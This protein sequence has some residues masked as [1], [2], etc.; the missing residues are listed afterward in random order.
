MFCRFQWS[1]VLA[2]F[3]V[4]RQHTSQNFISV[5]WDTATHGEEPPGAGE[6][7]AC[8]SLTDLFYAVQVPVHS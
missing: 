4:L 1:R 5:P 2:I 3:L 7:P 6:V 8:A